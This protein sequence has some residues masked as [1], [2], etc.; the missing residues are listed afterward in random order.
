MKVP[1]RVQRLVDSSTPLYTVERRC[2]GVWIITRE[3]DNGP[4]GIRSR[5][6][7]FRCVVRLLRDRCRFRTRGRTGLRLDHLRLP[8]GRVRGRPP[9]DAGRG[10]LSHLFDKQTRITTL[11]H[12]AQVVQGPIL[13]S[14]LRR[15][16]QPVQQATIKGR[17]R[18][19]LPGRN[20]EAGHDFV[21]HLGHF[22]RYSRSETEA[23]V[24]EAGF[25]ILYAD[26]D[27]ESTPYAHAVIQPIL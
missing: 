14:F 6:V 15:K 17:V 1:V 13:I 19:A 7:C 16:N 11:K 23:L 9:G 3:H 2:C 12:F 10:S 4:R 21:M 8:A 26:I 24:A 5:V 27:N 25:T 18:R 22:W 20:Q